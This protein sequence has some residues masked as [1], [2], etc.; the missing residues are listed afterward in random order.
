M[1]YATMI[2]GLCALPVAGVKRVLDYQ[3]TQANTADLPLLFPSLPR[4]EHRVATLTGG[5]DLPVMRVNLAILV[6]PTLQGRAEP[7]WEKCVAL[8][9][10]QIET[11]D[12]A[13]LTVGVVGYSTRLEVYTFGAGDN[14]TAYWTLV[15]EVE[16]Q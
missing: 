1:S 7:T 2:A 9:D 8:I 15:T 10:A 5:M 14:A 12:G 11:L 13:V 3:P 6:E 16:V 4:G